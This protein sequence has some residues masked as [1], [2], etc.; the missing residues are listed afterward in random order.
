MK[1]E[2]I[3]FGYVKNLGGYENCK[4]YMEATIEFWENPEQSLDIL[5]TR[6][7]EELDL[8]HGWRNLRYKYNQEIA[9]FR[10][11]ENAREEAEKKLKEAHEAWEMYAAFLAKHGIDPESLTLHTALDKATKTT[12]EIDAQDDLLPLNIEAIEDD[13]YFD[14][15]YGDEYDSLHDQ[16]DEDKPKNSYF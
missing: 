3:G 11:A 9:A 5:R 4:L 7:A 14:P 16:V 10:N 8:P 1:I 6:V 2:R 12:Q 15:C 13:D